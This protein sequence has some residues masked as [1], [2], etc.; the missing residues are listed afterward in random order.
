MNGDAPVVGVISNPASGHNRDQF[1]AIRAR[2]ERDGR[3]QHIVTSSPDEIEPALRELASR[4]I[5]VLAI[6]GGDGTCSAVLGTLLETMPF[7]R[8]PLIA[9]LPGGTAN[10][11]AGDIGIRGSL[12]RA[13]ARF[14]DWCAGDQRGEERVQRA[15]MRLDCGDGSAVRYGMFLGAGVIIQGTDYAH[16]EL[17]ARG[18]RD[19]FSL[20]LGTARTAWGVLRNDPAFRQPVAVDLALA[21]EPARHF[22]T[23]IL[24]V[25]TL[26]RLAFG[27]RP[28]WGTDSGHLGVTLIEGRC[29]RFATTFLSILR[30][31][32]NRNAVPGEGYHSWRTDSLALQLAGKLNLDGEIIEPGGAVTLSASRPLEFLRL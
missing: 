22:D 10:M 20:A 21:D 27:M 6:N 16:R 15:L 7:A 31:R 30:G 4:E 8:L 2:L 13:A 5:D 28:F 11:N 19:D 23:L 12:A 25:S 29:T 3:V 18:L 24:A 14:S 32:A 9:V 17:H 1:P 26:Q